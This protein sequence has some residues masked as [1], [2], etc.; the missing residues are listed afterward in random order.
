MQCSII[1]DHGLLVLPMPSKLLLPP[2]L[3]ILRDVE[4]PFKFEVVM[5]IVILEFRDCFVMSSSKH[6]GWC[7]IRIDCRGILEIETIDYLAL[8]YISSRTLACPVCSVHKTPTTIHLI[9]DLNL[10]F[11][12]P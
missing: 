10:R 8:T 1:N 9:S 2:L 3:P 4:R 5:L 7:F 6:P 11:S 12:T